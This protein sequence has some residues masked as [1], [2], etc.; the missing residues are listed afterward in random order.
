M[1]QHER[2]QIDTVEKKLD[3]ILFYLLDD[4]ETDSKGVIS[5][6]NDNKKRLDVFDTTNK[7][8]AG[9]VTVLSMVGGAAISLI[10]WVTSWAIN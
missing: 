2:N 5:T 7:V 4:P 9:Q 1:T 3:K 6:V 8:K 10:A